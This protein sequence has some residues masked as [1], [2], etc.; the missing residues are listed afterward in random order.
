MTGHTLS[1]DAGTTLIKA[2]V[3]D[4]SGRTLVVASRQTVLQSTGSGIVEQDMRAVRDAAIEASR[5]AVGR[6][7]GR[8]DRI[9][10]TAQ[11]D[12]AWFVD[13][14][15]EPL[16]PAILWNDARSRN[17]V[18]RWISG[19]I[20]DRA[21]DINGSQGNLGLPNAIMAHLLE[22]DPSALDRAS[23]VLTCGSWIYLSLTGRQALHV[24]EASAPWLDIAAGT[25][26]SELLKLYGLSGHSSLLP[27]VVSSA[28]S[29]TP[30][31]PSLAE[32]IGVPAGT[33]VILAPYDVVATAAGA[34]SIEPGDAFCI[35]GTTLCTGVVTADAL[36]KTPQSGLTLLTGQD[37]SIRAFPSLSGTAV[38]HWLASILGLGGPSEVTALAAGVAAG[39][40]GVTVWPYLSPAGERNPFLDPDARGVI[41][42]LSTGHTRAHLAKATLEGLSHVVRESL[43]LSGSPTSSLTIS[44]GGAASDQWCSTLADVTQLVTTR[45]SDEQVGAKGALLYGAVATGEFASLADASRHLL[46]EHTSFTPDSA[47]AELY[48]VRHADFIESR[49]A[50]AS[51]W[52]NWPRSGAGS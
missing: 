19:G 7:G 21:F 43:E 50:L 11:G 39:S 6:A 44:G 3:F 2:V 12:G 32:A 49:A 31:L 16:R 35:F 45:A 27:P 14:G 10:I 4:H 24:S 28:E 23:A 26:S 46:G 9:C 18:D 51:R 1:I 8:V 17:I 13:H 36:V 42:G 30:L 22:S 41:A 5:E 52:G 15:D 25:Y 29:V 48:S 37:T 34:G 38:L 47:S 40:D 33:P 20:L